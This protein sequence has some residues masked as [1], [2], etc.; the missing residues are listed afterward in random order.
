MKNIALIAPTHPLLN[1]TSQ[2]VSAEE[3]KS[4]EFQSLINNMLTLA[5]GEQGD[6]KRKTMVGLA[7]PQIGVLKRVI[8]VAVN[9][10]G[11]GEEPDLQVFINPEIIH[12]SDDKAEGR[13]GCFSTGNICGIVDRAQEIT[14]KYQ[15]TEGH[16]QEQTFTGF[17]A[18]IFQHELDHLNGIR[19]PDRIADD[20]HLHWVEADEFG[21]YREQWKTW[22]KHCD[23]KVWEEMKGIS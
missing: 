14:V 3:I 5:K 19:F 6:A 13:E 18:R 20:N 7:A 10:T 11:M 23:R 15:D 9:A 12:Y 1:H 4:A 2:E 22:T 8:V 17:V 21:N 16:V